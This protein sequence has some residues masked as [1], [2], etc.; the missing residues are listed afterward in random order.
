[1]LTLL[2]QARAYGLG[3]VL[4]TQ[5][6]V[7]LD[8][9]GLSNAGTWFL[10]RLQTERDK[11]RVI[12]GLEGASAQAGAS[13]NKQKMEATLAGLGKR[14]FLMN[15]VHEDAP[16]V[17]Q[18][19]WAMSYLCGPLTKDQIKKL[20][21]PVRAKT[22]AGADENGGAAAESASAAAA[23]T[24]RSGAGQ[25]PIVPAG[26]EE[27][28]LT[29][30]ERVPAGYRVEYRAGLLGRGKLHFV[31]RTDDVDVWRDFFAMQVIDGT[32]ADDIW[33]GAMIADA[34]FSTDES[35]DADAQFAELPAELAREKS[36]AVFAR[37][38]K[39]HLYREGSLQL[40]RCEALEAVSQ[41]GES[42]ADFRMR[43]APLL[44]AK[45]QEKKLELEADFRAKLDRASK[46]VRDAQARVSQKKWRFWTRLGTTL[47]VIFD[48]VMAA[49]GRN[50]PGRRRSLDP[51]IRTMGTEL[52]DSDPQADLEAAQ[53]EKD[54]LQQQFDTK[55]KAL[56]AG[57]TVAGLKLETVTFKPQKGDIDVDEVS[58]TWL[59][60][61]ITPAGAAEPLWSAS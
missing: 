14:V 31:R 54:Q 20:M 4:A 2:K 40:F 57:L 22:A 34:P 38:L 46:R 42:E 47:W 50:L 45:L 23:P 24:G 10:G 49:F 30:H 17:F 28:F 53:R 8:Y 13:F 35:P 37:H 7:D 60:F 19:R 25:R 59:P 9:K 44:P 16:V 18:S 15:N 32:P 51:A 12:E 43:L 11:A 58:L 41:P 36:Y 3:C 26:I 29:I 48:N 52:S 55:L 1:M 56:E 61:R 6:P 5:N 39:D 33:Q 27:K 21:D